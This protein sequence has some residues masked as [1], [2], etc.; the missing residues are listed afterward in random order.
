[1]FRQVV[2]NVLTLGIVCLFGSTFAV[3]GL[4]MCVKHHPSLLS[5]GPSA[6]GGAPVIAVLPPCPSPLPLCMGLGLRTCG[7]G[8]APL[9]VASVMVEHKWRVLKLVRTLYPSLLRLYP[10]PQPTHT[11][12]PAHPSQH[13]HQVR[14][15]TVKGLTPLHVG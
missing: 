1:M 5:C 3:Y 11:H 2:Y 15:R 12:T 7:K 10:C 9:P 6:V 8:Q 14:L 13:P 4:R